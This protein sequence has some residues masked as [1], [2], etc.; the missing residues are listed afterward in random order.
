MAV[1]GSVAAG[2]DNT[3]AWCYTPCAA[4]LQNDAAG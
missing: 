2:A 3:T 4:L 1:S